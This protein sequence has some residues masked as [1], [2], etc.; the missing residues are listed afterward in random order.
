MAGLERITDAAGDFG[1]LTASGEGTGLY[2]A[3][4]RPALA[5][6]P[7]RPRPPRRGAAAQ[8]GGCTFVRPVA[9]GPLDPEHKPVFDRRDGDVL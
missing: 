2:A 1:G 5:R 3:Q 6:P 4:G 7:V 8:R 9:A